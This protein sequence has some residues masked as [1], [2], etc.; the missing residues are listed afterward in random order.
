M[1]GLKIKVIIS[2]GKTNPHFR[3]IITNGIYDCLGHILRANLAAG[4]A[5]G[6]PRLY[7]YQSAAYRSD[8][9]YRKEQGTLFYKTPDENAGIIPTHGTRLSARVICSNEPRCKGRK[10]LW[11]QWAL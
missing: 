2:L 11:P 10:I 6:T 7:A 3:R 5:L 4:D 1:R 9:G 8:N